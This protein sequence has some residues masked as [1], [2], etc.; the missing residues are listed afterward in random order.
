MGM[1]PLTTGDG[2]TFDLDAEEIAEWKEIERMQLECTNDHTNIGE[3]GCLDC[4]YG[5][6]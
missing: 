1:R 3:D 4:G 2:D 5:A 6:K